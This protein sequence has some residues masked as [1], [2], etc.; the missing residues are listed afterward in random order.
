M[1]AKQS[2]SAST[3]RRRVLAASAIGTTIE[4]Y[5]FFIYSTSAALVFGTHFFSAFDPATALSLSMASLGVTFVVRP[6]GSA[7]SGH[8]GDRIG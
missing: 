1:P 8:F 7:V 6:F 5:D 3:E 4:W 2:S